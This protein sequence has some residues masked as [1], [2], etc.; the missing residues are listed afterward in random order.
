[1]VP[2][3]PRQS[4]YESRCKGDNND[5]DEVL[6]IGRVLNQAPLLGALKQERQN[7]CG[8]G[9]QAGKALGQGKEILIRGLG[10]ERCAEDAF[11]TIGALDSIALLIIL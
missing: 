2:G 8:D 4:G 5:E 11:K 10:F 7:G 1:M 9:Q 6:H 3:P